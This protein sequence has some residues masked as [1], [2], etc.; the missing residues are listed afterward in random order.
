MAHKVMI[1]FVVVVVVVIVVG[2]HTHCS[3]CVCRGRGRT[4]LTRF[5]YGEERQ[6]GCEFIEG[7]TFEPTKS[8]HVSV[9]CRVQEL[10]FGSKRLFGTLQG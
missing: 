2:V 10:L 4:T 8:W 5:S 6:G 7:K 1:D 9:V 3:L